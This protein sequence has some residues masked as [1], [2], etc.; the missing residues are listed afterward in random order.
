MLPSLAVLKGIPVPPY[1]RGLAL[2]GIRTG[3]LR[4]R[5]PSGPPT[6]WYPEPFDHARSVAQDGLR[7]SAGCDCG[8]D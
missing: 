8:R 5:H 3:C 2:S 4:R 7:R 1:L 6:V